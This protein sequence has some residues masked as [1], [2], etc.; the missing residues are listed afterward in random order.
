VLALYAASV[1][2]SASLLFLVQPLIAKIILPWFGGTSAVWT[3]VLVFFQLCVLG[4]YAYAHAL[5]TFL[6]ERAQRIVHCSLLIASCALMP[7]LPAET[8][9]PADATDPTGRIL[10]LLAATV[11]LPA[12]LLSATSP[13]LQV[14]YLR[15]GAR[16]TPYWLFALSN[17]G[18][19]LALLSFPL[20]LEPWFDASTLAWGWSALF[21]VFVVLCVTVARK[22]ASQPRA[23]DPVVTDEHA[24]APSLIQMASWI[25]FSAC[26]S[27]MLVSLSTHLST[28]VAPIPLLWV[29]PL[30]V[31]LLTFI[32]CFSNTRLYGR[33]TFFPLLAAA[34]GCLAYLYVQGD[35]NWHIRVLIPI[36]LG[37]LFVIC[38]ACHGE[39]VQRRPAAPFLTRFYLLIALGGALGGLFVAVIA[40]RIFETYLELPLLLAVIAAVNVFL[41]WRRRGSKVTL[42]PVRIAMVAGVVALSWFLAQAELIVRGENLLVRRNFYGVLRVRDEQVGEEL[43]R[44]NLI[45]GTISHGY[46]FLDEPYRNVASAYFSPNSGVGRVLEAFEDRGPIRYGVIGLGA[47]ILASYA[48]SG[49]YVR[50]YEI[51]PAVAIIADEMFTFL[52]QARND[53]ADLEVL[54]GDARL[55]LERQPRQDF[56]V[57]AVDAF[58]S[59][60]IPTH[61]LTR[62]AMDVYFRHLKPDGVLAVHISNRYLDLAPVALR[63]AEHVGRSATVV[64]HASDGM[65]YASV[66]VLI[67]SNRELLSHPQF[68]GAD[69]RPA[70]ADASFAGWT[71]RYGS[72]WPILTLRGSRAPS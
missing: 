31:Y 41:Q 57:L 2:L 25:G 34:I 6:R 11:G 68:F 23:Q 10:L 36:H 65:S 69:M 46:Q 54:L 70:I 29:L 37:A 21:I 16:E 32:L 42:W 14:W 45:H 39:V 3:A 50:L 44:R 1:T 71:D 64:R 67:T 13:L 51:N 49:D 30:A 28:N 17:F 55:T 43:G 26:A 40:P 9:R 18:S 22:S 24:R 53:G 27:A 62:E 8:W 19:L 38:L 12:F 35:Q 47:G 48:R 15:R 5:T 20:L 52:S 63:A 7:I 72:L 56:D 4:G 59:D 33:R 58:S 61:L 66:W 60:A